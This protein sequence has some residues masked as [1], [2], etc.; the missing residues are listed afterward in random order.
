MYLLKYCNI[1]IF[2]AN[3]FFPFLCIFQKQFEEK[4]SLLSIMCDYVTHLNKIRIILIRNVAASSNFRGE[5]SS[6]KMR[7]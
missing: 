4:L 1:N 3:I 5:H 7:S 2:C 6:G